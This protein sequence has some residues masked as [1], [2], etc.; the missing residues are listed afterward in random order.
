M[1]IH[2]CNMTIMRI[3]QP[4]QTSDFIDMDERM[5]NPIHKYTLSFG[6]KPEASLDLLGMLCNDR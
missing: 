2:A 4:S 6:N 5:S 3:M 1:I